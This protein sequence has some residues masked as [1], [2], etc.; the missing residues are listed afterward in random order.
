MQSGS[1]SRAVAV[2]GGLSNDGVLQAIEK[3]TVTARYVDPVDPSDSAQAS[4]QVDP[5]SRVFDSRTG[6]P[7]SGAQITVIDMATGL[8]ATVFSD[9]GVSTYPSTVI[10]GQS[11]TDGAGH[12]QVLGE[13]EFRF[14]YLRAGTYALK[15][16]APSGYSAPTRLSDDALVS[17]SSAY[18]PSTPTARAARRSCST[19]ARASTSTFRSTRAAWRSGCRSAPPPIASASAITWATRSPS[20]TPTR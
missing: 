1:A 19:R 9:D 12:K 13:G 16:K 8:P 2:G 17:V 14:P 20:R 4:A 11:V 5:T 18:S 7:V 10:S 6:K 15:V 3:S